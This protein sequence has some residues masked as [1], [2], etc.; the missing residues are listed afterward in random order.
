MKKIIL[1]VSILLILFLLIKSAK[2][3]RRCNKVVTLDN[4]TK[5]KFKWLNSYPSGFTNIHTCNEIDITIKTDYIKNITK[6]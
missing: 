2:K 4:G 1:Y 6:I 3:D 5:I